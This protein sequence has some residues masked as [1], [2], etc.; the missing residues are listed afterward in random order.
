MVELGTQDGFF[1]SRARTEVGGAGHARSRTDKFMLTAVLLAALV[2]GLAVP[3]SG[4][5]ALLAGGALLSAGLLACLYRWPELGMVLLVFLVSDLLFMASLVDIRLPI[6]GL[7]LRDLMF[8]TMVGILIVKTAASDFKIKAWVG[9]GPARPLLLFFCVGVLATIVA[10]YRSV[11]LL[12]VLQEVRTLAYYSVFFIIL[13]LVR[14]ERGAMFVL[15]ALLGIATLTASTY[16]LQYFVGVDMIFVGGSVARQ[17][18]TSGLVRVQGHAWSLVN[19]GF[20]V[21]TVQLLFEP[22]L[23]RRLGYLLAAVGCGVAVLVSFTRTLWVADLCV[24]LLCLVLLLK[25]VRVRT[26][27]YACIVVA[28]LIGGIWVL[29]VA[30]GGEGTS[31]VA[32]LLTR[33]EVFLSGDITQSKTIMPRLTE[34][35]LAWDR[36]KQSPFLGLGWGSKYYDYPDEVWPI[37]WDDPNAL[38]LPRYIHNTYVWIA[39]KAGLP[40]LA[41]FLWVCYLFVKDCWRAYQGSTGTRWSSWH[42]S[43]MLAFLAMMIVNL[44]SPTFM[45]PA[46]ATYAATLMGLGRVLSCRTKHM[47]GRLVAG[48]VEVPR[49][50]GI[51][52][53]SERE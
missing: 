18:G 21:G 14:S 5:M 46:G 3:L 40:A 4:N 13:C 7:E 43:V 2:L 53:G 26:L 29:S 44:V 17:P 37:S 6:G 27:L 10:T 15:H 52:R 50:G 41:L 19:I 35:K 22:K 33:A 31:L 24:G 8:L 30:R 51:D 38:G 1:M 36:I 42:L 20:I 49:G 16:L 25:R 48:D 9:S 23:G 28:A 39:L 12:R 47:A 34:M 11:E 45:T 32:G